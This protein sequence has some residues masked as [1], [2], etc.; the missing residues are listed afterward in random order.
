VPGEVPALPVDVDVQ[1]VEGGPALL[2]ALPE[3]VADALQQ[4]GDLG[5]GELVGRPGTVQPGAPQRLVGVDVAHPA[6]QRLVEQGPLDLGVPAAQRRAEGVGVE[7]GVQRVDR[8]VRQPGRDA[9]AGSLL[10]GQ[11]AEGPLVDEAQLAAAVGEPEPG[12][13]VHLVGLVG[14]LDEQLAAHAEV[15]D[16]RPVGRAAVGL[17][18]RQPQ[19]LAAAMGGGEGA[20]G[21]RADEVLG[22]LEVAAHRPRVVHLDGGDGAAGD[23]AVQAAPDDL[24]LGQLGHVRRPRIRR[25]PRR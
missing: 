23:P 22:A 16:Q 12:T 13:Q 2:E 25:R 10:D 8:D 18:H 11:P 20:A 17:G 15:R 21:E 5:P 19:V 9:V 7:A 4:V 1:G 6:D 3:H 14:L 24:D